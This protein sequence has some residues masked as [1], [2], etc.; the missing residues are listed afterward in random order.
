[1]LTTKHTILALAIASSAVTATAN[2]KDGFSIGTFT[3]NSTLTHT[4]ERNTGS[5]QTPSLSSRVEESDFGFG[6]TVGYQFHVT[7][8]IFLG[9]EAFYQEQDIETRNLNNLLITQLTL[10]NTYGVKFKAGVDVT[11]KLSVYGLIGQTNLDF[12]IDNSYPFVP[13]MRTATRDID[14]LTIGFGAQYAIS[15]RWS[16]TAEYSQLND[17]S[18]DPIPEVAV[19]GKINDNEIDFSS[20]SF[21]VNYNF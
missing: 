14:E 2:A 16:V 1:M 20:I 12:D 11:D 8:D 10:N 7:D 5:N 17:V 4:I 13:P 6:V 19:P 21:G 18:F 9:A 3:S 15:D